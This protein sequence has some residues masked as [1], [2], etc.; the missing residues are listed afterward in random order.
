MI[1]NNK[2][3]SILTLVVKN[4]LRKYIDFLK[5]LYKNN[6]ILKCKVN[7]SLF[8]YNKLFYQKNIK[9]FDYIL[10]IKKIGDNEI[11]KQAYLVGDYVIE[12]FEDIDILNN[13]Y[14]RKSYK[15]I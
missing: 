14:M 12:K 6:A 7:M 5:N 11:L 10:V 9:N 4:F 13:F 3:N 1:I 15:Y 2:V 8:N